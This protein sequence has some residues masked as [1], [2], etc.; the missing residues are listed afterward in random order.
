MI[1]NECYFTLLRTEIERGSPPRLKLAMEC[2]RADY[3]K[4]KVEMGELVAKQAR[5]RSVCRM[6]CQ[7]LIDLRGKDDLTPIM[8]ACMVY[9]QKIMSGDKQGAQAIDAIAAWLL[10]EQASVGAQGSR[11]VV[12]TTDRR[13]GEVVHER[14][15]GKTIMEAMGWANLPPSVQVH[16]KSRRLAVEPA[17]AA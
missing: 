8:W 5:H 2:I 11:Q 12:R 7:G 4:R 14:G 9:R 16:I 13:T 3:V 15:R 10:Q 1:N 6:T 17:L